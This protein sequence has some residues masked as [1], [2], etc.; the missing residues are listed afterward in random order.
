MADILSKRERSKLMARIRGRDTQPERFLRLALRHRRIPYRA[1]RKIA[2]V[3]V[4]LILPTHRVAI[5]VHGCFWHGCPRHY[6][7]PSTHVRF[8]KEKVERNKRRDVAQ[9]AQVRRAGWN[10]VV[11]WEHALRLNGDRVADRLARRARRWRTVRGPVAR[12]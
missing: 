6:T 5:F 12:V 8:W 7:A 10:V 4:D 1:Y 2:G 11:V 3:T 9:E